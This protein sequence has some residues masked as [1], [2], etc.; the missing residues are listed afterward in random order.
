MTFEFL[1]VK[2]ALLQHL[3]DCVG[4]VRDVG[5]IAGYIRQRKQLRIAAHDL[6]FMLLAVFADGIAN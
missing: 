5:R 1:R 4:I 6:R 2:A 3:A